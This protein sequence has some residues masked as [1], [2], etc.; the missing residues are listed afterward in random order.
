MKLP[1]SQNDKHGAAIK[2]DS[3]QR[4]YASRESDESDAS[5]I[6]TISSFHFHTLNSMQIILLS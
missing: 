1:S 5:V 2:H 6:N 3:A 4:S